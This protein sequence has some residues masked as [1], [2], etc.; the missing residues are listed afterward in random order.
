MMNWGYQYLFNILIT[1]LYCGMFNGNGHTYYA[2]RGNYT[3]LTELPIDT[4]SFDVFQDGIFE[5]FLNNL[6][7]TICKPEKILPIITI[8]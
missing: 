2:F 8:V 4:D 7:T 1:I 3:N 6:T 5:I